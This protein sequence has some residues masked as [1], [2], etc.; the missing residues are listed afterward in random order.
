MPDELLDEAVQGQAAGLLRLPGGPR[1]AV[2]DLI[3]DVAELLLADTLGLRQGRVQGEFQFIHLVG[4]LRVGL[5]EVVQLDRPLPAVAP[6]FDVDGQRCAGFVV[7][8]L[9]DGLEPHKQRYSTAGLSRPDE[10]CGC[11]W[12]IIGCLTYCN[13][14]AEAELGLLFFVHS[15]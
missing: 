4:E 10:K 6:G 1:L 15:L 9:L 8:L 7:D 3:N 13:Y 14:D 2:D 11:H 5:P 12:I